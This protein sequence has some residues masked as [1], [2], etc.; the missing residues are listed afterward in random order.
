MSSADLSEDLQMQRLIN[1]T[2]DPSSSFFIA[3]QNITKNDMNIESKYAQIIE[4]WN[5]VKFYTNFSI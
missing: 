2:K 4:M 1:A 5:S 3:Q